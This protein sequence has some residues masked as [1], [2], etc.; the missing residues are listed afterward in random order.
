MDLVGWLFWVY[1][2]FETVFQSIWSHPPKRGKKRKE[3]ID[4][5]KNVQTTPIRTYCKCSKPLSY[6]NPNCRTPQH[7]KFSQHHRTTRQPTVQMENEHVACPSV[8]P[9]T[10]VQRKADV[11]IIRSR[12]E[13][14]VKPRQMWSPS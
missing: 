4:E 9:Q 6:C 10:N 3:R 5:S 13:R 7:W 2:P 1:R 14:E 8:H 11:P 12:R